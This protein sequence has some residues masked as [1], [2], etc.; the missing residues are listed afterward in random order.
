MTI[1]PF[2]SIHFFVLVYEEN[3]LK[4]MDSDLD[5]DHV[6]AILLGEKAVLTFRLAKLISHLSKLSV[7]FQQISEKDFALI[8]KNESTA[9]KSDVLHV[10]KSIQ[11]S[12]L[13]SCPHLLLDLFPIEDVNYEG[14]VGLMIDFLTEVRIRLLLVPHS[15]SDHC[16][17]DS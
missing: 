12:S 14:V 7:A 1:L 6:P 9:H 16:H 3:I 17:L 8:S 11:E 10:L 15:E 4:Y 5:K 2:V 13:A